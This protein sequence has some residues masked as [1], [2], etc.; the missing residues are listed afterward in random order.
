MT[1]IDPTDST[2]W[3]EGLLQVGYVLD[4]WGTQGWL[5]IVPE[6]NEAAALLHASH[7]WMQ[8]P[9]GRPLQRAQF[10]VQQARRHSQA[11]VALIEGT[12][13]RT[14]AEGMRGWTIHARR[15]DF[16]PVRKD[17]YYWVDL[18]GCQ[19]LNRDG[20]ELGTVSSLLDSGAQS[21]LQLKCMTDGKSHERLIPFVNAYIVAVDLVARRIVADWLPE[22]D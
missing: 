18:I 13:T 21:V 17:E 20:L 3:P 15:E 4:A 8:S 12:T 9:Q 14:Q 2:R 7:W 22:Y 16:P 1:P 5:K 11:V 19:V 6:S 10:A